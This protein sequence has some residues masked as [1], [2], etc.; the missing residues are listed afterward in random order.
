MSGE[1]PAVLVVLWAL[2]TSLLLIVEPLDRR[3]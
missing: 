1:V 3:A 2:M